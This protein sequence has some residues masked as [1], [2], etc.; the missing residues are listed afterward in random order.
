MGTFRP[1][2]AVTPPVSVSV[3]PTPVVVQAGGSIQVT[4]T[5]Q[6][7]SNT[8]VTWS[9]SG[10]GC[11][12]AGCGT[13]NNANTN[14]VTYVA[15]ITV[16]SPPTVTLTA[17]AVADTTRSAAASLTIVAAPPLSI[18]LVQQA[19]T[20]VSSGTRTLS[21]P[22][23]GASTAGDLIVVG[24]KWGDQTVSVSSITDNL[25]N[26]Y[27]SALGP[28]TWSA[29]GKRAQVFY[30]KNILGGPITV[31]VTLTSTSTSSLHL[32]Q[33]EYA[34]VDTSAP[35]DAALAGTGS[36][37]SLASGAVT[38]QAPNELLL[39]FGITDVGPLSPGAGFQADS[40]YH[41]NLVEESLSTTSG[42]YNATATQSAAANWIMQLVT[43]RP[44]TLVDTTPPTVSI[45]SP[46]NGATLSGTA[47]LTA[48]ATDDVA[49]ASVQFQLDGANIGSALVTSPYSLS[50]NTASAQNGIHSL[51]AVA[52]DTAGNSAFST[53][54]A[55]TISN[56]TSPGQPALVHSTACSNS[57]GLSGS[58]WPGTPPYTYRCPLPEL[59]TAGNTLVVA[60]GFDATGGNQTF[61]VTDQQGDAF[62]LD[63]SSPLN[64]NRQLR[65]YR[66]T[67][68]AANSAWVDVQLQSGTLNGYWQPMLFEL[69]NAAAL[70]ASSCNTGTSNLITAGPLT[71]SAAGDLLL[72]VSY[73]PTYARSTSFGAGS[74][75]N[76]SWA[77]A[78]TLL[79]DGSASQW[80]V[81]NSNAAINPAFTAGTANPFLSCAVALRASS[82][83]GT[84]TAFNIYHQ[85]HDAM[86]QNAPNP[87]PV[88]VV[89]DTP[90]AVYLSYV[91]NDAITSVTSSPAPNVGWVASGA[92]FNG[93]N[94]HNHV[95]FYCASWTSPP[96]F[97]TVNIARA[98]STNDSINMMYVVTKGTCNL[99]V[100][101]GGQAANQTSQVSQL[102]VCNGCLTPT[103]TND[104][105]FQEGGQYSCTGT[106]LAAPAVG[107][108][109]EAG[110][111]NGITI[112]GPAQ[113]D[114][115][116][117][118]SVL[119]NGSSL[120]PITVTLDEAC[121]TNESYW[122]SRLAAYKTLP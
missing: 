5:V 87:W 114:E 95:N 32:Y 53:A 19:E 120:A 118:W 11:T 104:I 91:G 117:F 23:S 2:S 12:G 109:F 54:V 111:F 26:T 92:D 78:H 94:G 113:T 44:N 7:A 76:I 66:A 75:S 115:N 24:V 20:S 37:T 9:L 89:V 47:V 33:L 110:W 88:G 17:T 58:P 1:A 90:G 35:L 60:F 8:S 3:S 68:V 99:D 86:P 79:G 102:T 48:S 100:D 39:G 74:Q 29:G 70:D 80:G 107:G 49:V 77:L 43:F 101:S 21:Q 106:G 69:D 22:F 31:T 42:S 71:P 10:D 13:L 55:I 73:A 4:A 14:V 25:G 36:G 82:T 6:N 93:T 84:P 30:A 61:A 34:G 15:P 103:V 65:I 85:E 64:N 98:A 41:A 119:S 56:T 50:W 105:I 108:L 16:P 81:Y 97:V 62:A 116:N 57:A 27:S 67:N 45:V 72:Q 18:H 96:G 121:I 38:T 40:T 63:V 52:R 46:A 112:D 83:G 51:R 28:T 59:T 122:A